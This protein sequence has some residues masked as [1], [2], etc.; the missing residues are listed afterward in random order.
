MINFFLAIENTVNDRIL[1]EPR[2]LV[3]QIVTRWL[4]PLIIIAVL[5][6]SA[7]LPFNA[8]RNHYVAVIGL[9]VAIGGEIGRA[10]CRERV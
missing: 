3:R 1:G 8:S 7:V 5:F 10:S 6:F 9:L 4:S 2:R